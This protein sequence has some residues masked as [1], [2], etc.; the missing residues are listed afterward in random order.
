MFSL[1][2]LLDEKDMVRYLADIYPFLVFTSDF[3]LSLMAMMESR[4]R[5]GQTNFEV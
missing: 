1:K 4:R 3:G 2:N 5:F